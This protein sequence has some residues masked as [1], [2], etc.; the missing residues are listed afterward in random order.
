MQA[1]A[2]KLLH[3]QQN[4]VYHEPG[5]RLY[6]RLRTVLPGGPWQAFLANSGAE[7]VEAAVKLARAATGR[8]AV[9]VFQGG[10]H[11][12]TAQAMALTTAKNVYRGD[13]EPLPGSVY[14]ADYPY[15]YRASGGAHDPAACTC[16]WEARFDLLLHHARL[17]G[18]GRRRDVEPVLGEGGFVVPRPASCPPPRDHR[19]PRHPLVAV[20]VQTGVGRTGELFA[21]RHWDVEPDVLVFAKGSPPACP[22]GIIAR[23]ELMARWRPGAHGGTFGGNVVAAAAANATLDV[24]EGESSSTTRGAGRSSWTASARS[25]GRH[26]ASA[27]VRGLGLMVA[28]EF[29]RP[30][31]ETG[32]S[33]SGPLPARPGRGAGPPPHRP[34]GRRLRQRGAD[35][36]AL[37][38]TAHEADL[39]CESSTRRSPRRAP[40]DPPGGRRT[41]SAGGPAAAAA[42]LVE[43]AIGAER[44]ARRRRGCRHVG[45][46]AAGLLDD[47][48]RRGDVQ[49]CMPVSNMASAAPSATSA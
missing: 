33:R 30:G 5:L 20:E 26:P 49:L 32:A 16:D 17:P 25:R 2:A 45:H 4:I 11:G 12:R 43:V 9:V 22:S 28:L 7:A 46:P 3:G 31:R 23:E 29:V 8:P 37:V 18:E 1:Q 24:V 47:D 14:V 19:P 15:C 27:T 36:P 44:S 39:A 6:E 34:L 40:D 38:T 42:A 35:H 21:V 41:R 13:F 10:F 48:V